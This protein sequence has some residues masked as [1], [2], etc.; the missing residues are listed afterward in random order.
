LYDKTD[1]QG[2]RFFAEKAR[3]IACFAPQV[4]ADFAMPRD[5][6]T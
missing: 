1:S 6:A 2:L 5:A 3:K 4:F